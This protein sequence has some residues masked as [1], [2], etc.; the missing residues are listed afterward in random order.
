MSF[1]CSDALSTIQECA[2]PVVLDKDGT[3]LG[4]TG[5]A[6]DKAD[7][8]AS[9]TVGNIKIDSKAPK[10]DADLD[11]TLK[12][13]YCRGRSATVNIT[14]TDPAPAEGITTSGVKEIKYRVN[15]GD[16]TTVSDSTATVNVQLTGS[17]M[18]TVEFWAGD[19]AGNYET[20][21]KVE[22]KY[23]TIA[24][25]ITHSQAGN[26]AGWSNADISVR[27]RAEDDTDGS[28][29]DKD[30]VMCGQSPAAAEGTVST[31]PSNA[32]VLNCDTS[33][34]TETSGQLLKAQA[35]DLAGNT[36]TDS[37]TVK[38]DKTAPT[39]AAKVVN[40]DG[41]PRE[42]NANGWY[43][44]AARVRFTCSDALSGI[45]TCPADV[46][47][48]T[49]GANQEVIGTAEDKA[50]N[51]ATAKLTVNVDSVKPTL[52]SVS[53]KDGAIYILAAVPSA[54]CEATDSDSGLDGACSVTVTGGSA[55]G[56]GTFNF[57]ATAKDK[58]GNTTTQSGSYT[59]IYN[60]VYGTA[61]FLQPIND[62]AHT[63]GLTT[64][65]FKAGSTVPVKFQLK[66]AN[67][68]VVQANSAPLWVTPAKGSATSEPISEE[69]YGDV[70]TSG[71]TYRWDGQQYIYNWAS[72]KNG[73]GYYWRVG[74]KL[75]DNRTYAV[76][77]GLR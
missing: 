2:G 24:P 47:V 3:G 62:T 37:V 38:L 13:G 29:L 25:T 63:T 44:S 8:E 45:A 18:A 28:G 54:T 61:F 66:D 15:G 36:G 73:N 34:K 64:S 6:T 42:P 5:K 49:N 27:F 20:A 14:A 46:V 33:W 55:N 74:V 41:T 39:I 65:V 68:K 72:P 59:V 19:N 75:D 4:A 7:N 30:T 40:E 12:N 17:G 11:C 43:N 35:D 58:A 48:T 51:K 21:N 67:G 56:V 57:T 9:A 50:D 22:I 71:T 10:S 53:V 60:V 52:T 23:D 76:H 77:I 31:D 69:L 32:K 1:T 16:V 70:A 26:A